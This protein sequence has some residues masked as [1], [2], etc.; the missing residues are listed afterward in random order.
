MMSNS[1]HIRFWNSY[2]VRFYP[3]WI[4]EK[5]VCNYKWCNFS[6]ISHSQ[7]GDFAPLWYSFFIFSQVDGQLLMPT[8]VIC[9]SAILPE[10]FLGDLPGYWIVYATPSSYMD[11]AGWLKGAIHFRT[12]LGATR[13]NHQSI[14]FGV[15]DSHYDFNLFYVMLY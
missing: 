10:A 1:N 14:L 5:I 4:W 2:E 3:N 15:H 9:Q 13:W 11:C 7:T 12:V 8:V 6:R